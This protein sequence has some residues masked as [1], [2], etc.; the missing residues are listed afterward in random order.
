MAET[1]SATTTGPGSQQALLGELRQAGL[2]L[3]TVVSQLGGEQLSSE[4]LAQA[5]Q[6]RLAAANSGCNTSCGRAV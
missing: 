3:D 4:A 2:H 5:A 6:A 1:T